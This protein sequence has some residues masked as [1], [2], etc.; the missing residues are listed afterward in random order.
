ML[1]GLENFEYHIVHKDFYMPASYADYYS[2]GAGISFAFSHVFLRNY[3][4]HIAD[5]SDIE[6][7]G[8]IIN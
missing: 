6:D 7:D 5:I 2:V 8:S 1:E 3:L 4:L